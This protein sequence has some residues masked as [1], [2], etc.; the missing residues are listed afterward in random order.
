MIYGSDEKLL[1]FL[2]GKGTDHKGRTYESML[3]WTDTQIEQ[4]HDAIQWLFPLHEASG[5]FQQAPVI[6]KAELDKAKVDPV[7][8][9]NLV[10]ATKRMEQFLAIGEYDDQMLQGLWCRKR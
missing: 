2:S 1:L 9:I 7:I 5:H 8:L 6:T 3:V 4:A 10:A